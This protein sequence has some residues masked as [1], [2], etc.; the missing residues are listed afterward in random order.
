[1][2]TLTCAQMGGMCGTKISAETKEEMLANSMKHVQEAHPEMAATITG[3][4]KDDPKMVEWQ[5]KFDK[6][7]EM[8]SEN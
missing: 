4:S 7:W 5:Q 1:M 6:T 8:T 2:K 3:M